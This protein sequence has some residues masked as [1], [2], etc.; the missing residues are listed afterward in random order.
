MF[1]LFKKRGVEETKE[2]N[3]NFLKYSIGWDVY[4]LECS[5]SK[6]FIGVSFSS[7][8]KTAYIQPVCIK[9]R[10]SA[11]RERKQITLEIYT[12]PIP[13]GTE[14]YCFLFELTKE[15][16]RKLNKEIDTLK[17]LNL[18]AKIK[19]AK[20]AIGLLSND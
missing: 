2:V 13:P 6:E 5:S 9:N 14:S 3:F 15:S 12:T 17:A 16:T 7:N 20:Q 1:K 8:R 4:K 11:D 18:A 19:E 10:E